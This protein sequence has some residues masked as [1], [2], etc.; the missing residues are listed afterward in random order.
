MR[1]STYSTKQREAILNLL[2]SSGSGHLSADEITQLLR[3][4]GIN[5][6]KSTVYRYL[7]MLTKSNVLRRYMV[8]GVAC[9]S[10]IGDPQCREHYHLFCTRCGELRHVTC[11]RLDELNAHL[12]ADHNFSLDTTQTV[13]YGL[14]EGCGGTRA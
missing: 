5:V 8:E 6:G 1:D 9:Y 12:C 7:N 2:T 4:Q 11:G 3:E 14:C 13:F 10:Y